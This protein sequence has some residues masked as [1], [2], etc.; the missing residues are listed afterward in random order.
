MTK[1]QFDLCWLS[2]QL[3]FN[4]D[5][6]SACLHSGAA[7]LADEV[8]PKSIECELASDADD[9]SSTGQFEGIGADLIGDRRILFVHELK[10]QSIDKPSVE[11]FFAESLL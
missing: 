2:C 6:L 10:R 11:D 7:H 1:W 9:D 4:F 5:T 3:Q 8:T